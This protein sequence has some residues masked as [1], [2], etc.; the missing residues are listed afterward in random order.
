MPRTAIVIEAPDGGWAL[1]VVAAAFIL[2]QGEARL[3]MARI[4]VFQSIYVNPDCPFGC[5]PALLLVGIGLLF[6]LSRFFFFSI[7]VRFAAI[8]SQ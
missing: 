7:V 3:A 6:N 2:V 1:A 8:M 4:M 5:R